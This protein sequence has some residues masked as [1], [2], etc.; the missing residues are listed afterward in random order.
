MRRNGIAALMLIFVA[1]GASHLSTLAQGTASQP[2]GVK[3]PNG[4]SAKVVSVWFIRPNA[5]PRFVS[6]YPGGD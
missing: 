2:A 4:E 1:V 3:G 6:A 5:F